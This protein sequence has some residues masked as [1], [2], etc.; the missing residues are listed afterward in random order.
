MK[1]SILT[2]LF[3][4]SVASIFAQVELNYFLPAKIQYN[5][6]IPTPKSVI[7]HEV[8]EWHITHDRLVNY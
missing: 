6:A 5:P 7:G 2:L 3:L 8:G 1:K 4:T